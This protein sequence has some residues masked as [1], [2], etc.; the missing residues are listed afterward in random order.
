MPRGSSVA[1][2]SRSDIK[3]LS[4]LAHTSPVPNRPVTGHT[5]RH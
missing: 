5:A 3:R 2:Q 1:A 4:V